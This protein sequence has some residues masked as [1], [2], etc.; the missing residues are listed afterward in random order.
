MNAALHLPSR[1]IEQISGH[2]QVRAVWRNAMNRPQGSIHERVM[3][4]LELK[5][6][7]RGNLEDIPT[8]GPLVVVAN[9]PFGII[10][11]PALGSLLERVRPDVMFVTNSLLAQLPELRDRIFAVDPFG[12]AAQA[13]SLAVRGCLRHLRAGGALVVFPA[14]EVSSLRPPLGLVRDAPWQPMAA[15]LAIKTGASVL[16]IYF[17]GGNRRRFHLAGLLHPALRTLMLASEMLSQRRRTIR[18]AIGSPIDAARYQDA[19]QLTS[20]LRTITYGLARQFRQAPIAVA[21]DTAELRREVASLTPILSCENY[22]VYLE[23]A[24]RLPA[25][26]PELARLRELTFRAA[27]E[28][29]GQARDWDEFDS[30]YWH[31]FIWRTDAQEIAGAYRLADG[32]DLA[33]RDRQGRLYCETLFRFPAAWRRITAQGA[34]LGRSFVR[35]AYQRELLPLLLLWQG[36]GHFVLSRPHLRYL[37]GPVSIS[38]SYTPAARALIANFFSQSREGV[39]PRNLLTPAIQWWPGQAWQGERDLNA[40]AKRVAQLEPDGKGLPVL[41]RQYANLGGEVVCFNL[42]HRFSNT[43]DGLVLLD[44]HRVPARLLKRYFGEAGVARFASRPAA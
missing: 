7:L 17:G 25:T 40:L 8:Q 14:G 41:L 23:Q 10:E 6:D 39:R 37:F 20:S 16:P 15:R 11:G 1:V 2:E 22:R 27:G 26:L 35:P 9:H 19:E 33:Q 30:S 32:A 21:P 31:L 28:G 29:T 18:L 42:D 3:A 43:L 4:E 12:G 5:L 44:L 38:A 34:E 13:N 36:I 24:H